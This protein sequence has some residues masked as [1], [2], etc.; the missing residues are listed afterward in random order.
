MAESKKLVQVLWMDAHTQDGMT[1][2]EL[3][4]LLQKKGSALAPCWVV[5]WQVAE[6]KETLVIASSILPAEPKFE[7]GET[8]YRRLSFIPKALIRGLWE[9]KE[10]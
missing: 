7:I 8:F 6:T 3:T 10:K 4:E 2:K 1:E 9:L 5:G